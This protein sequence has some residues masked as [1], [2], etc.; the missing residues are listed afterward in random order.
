MDP[1]KDF[2][3]NYYSKV[4]SEK[5]LSSFF[6]SLT[7]RAL[8]VPFRKN[9]KEL[10]KNMILE[11]GAGKGEHYKFLHQEFET[12]YML[13]L[14]PEP[15]NFKEFKGARWIK[16]DI[17]DVNLHLPQ[18]DRILMMCVLHHVDKPEVALQNVK[19]FLKPGGV[20][21]LFLPSDP[22]IL[23]RVNRKLFVTPLAKKQGFCDYD[24]VNAREHRNHYWALK[25]ELEFQFKDYKI[26]KKY[27]P[28]G[29]RLGNL[30]LFSIWNIRQSDI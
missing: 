7:H 18:F 29:L 21:S 8:E 24:L 5:G 1:V 25:K 16:A 20:F 23:N 19:N 12:Y 17:C 27:Y 13:D 22:G 10:K 14:V 2:Y 3:D 9:E 6:N 4:F 30:S 26:S 11:I 15:P 28:F